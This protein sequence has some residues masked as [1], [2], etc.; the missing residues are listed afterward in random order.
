M[1][2]ADTTADRQNI[3]MELALRELRSKPRE[4]KLIGTC[5]FCDENVADNALFCDSNC[6]R[7]WEKKRGNR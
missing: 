6:A 3:E 2:E 1:D 7:D 5:H 4:L